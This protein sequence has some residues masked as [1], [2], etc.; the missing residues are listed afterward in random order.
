MKEETREKKYDGVL[1]NEIRFKKIINNRS[2][3]KPP[4]PIKIPSH[5]RFQIRFSR[6]GI[7]VQR[8]EIFSHNL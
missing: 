6:N 7:F 4:S 8:E 2:N 3:K 5:V 1:E